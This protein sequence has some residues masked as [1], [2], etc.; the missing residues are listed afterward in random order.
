MTAELKR[1][2]LVHDPEYQSQLLQRHDGKY[3]R[4][5]DV[6]ALQA[7]LVK[8]GAL[9]PDD[10]Y[11]SKDWRHADALGRIEWLIRMLANKNEEID[12]WVG[13]L[14]QKETTE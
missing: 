14:N 13:M 7:K 12:V 9:L 10:L 1:Y 11:D 4:F 3:V 8:V 2:N 6:Q 5:A